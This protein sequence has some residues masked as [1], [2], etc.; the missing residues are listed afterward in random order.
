METEETTTEKTYTALPRSRAK[1]A[2]GLLQDVKRAILAE[3]RRIN[4]GLFVDTTA[5]QLLPENKVPACGTVGCFAGWVSILGRPTGEEN[6]ERIGGYD[7]YDATRI[8]NGDDNEDSLNLFTVGRYR[9][10]VFN[11]G[12]GDRCAKTKPGTVAHAR[13]VVARINKFMRVNEKALKARKLTP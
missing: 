4:M 9:N 3:P 13:A 2:W 11:G 10:Y 1:T 8:L 7:D 12:L 6:R 5:D